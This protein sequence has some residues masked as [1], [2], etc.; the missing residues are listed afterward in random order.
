MVILSADHDADTPVGRPIGVPI[1]VAPVVEWVI[2]VNRALI[3][4][5][6]VVDAA[7]TVFVA[8]IVTVVADDV[9]VEQTPF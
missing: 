4:N 7:P 9:A 3:H 6:G 5:V 8:S 1:P 2:A